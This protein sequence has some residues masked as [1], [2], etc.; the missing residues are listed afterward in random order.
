MC[1]QNMPHKNSNPDRI[2]KNN[3]N[4][5]QFTITTTNVK[6][7]INPNVYTYHLTTNN[8]QMQSDILEITA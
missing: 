6:H 3:L 7:N 4:K 1:A 2:T 5:I 8:I